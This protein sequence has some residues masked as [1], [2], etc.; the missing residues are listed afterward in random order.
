VAKLPE[1]TALAVLYVGAALAALLF[2]A[3]EVIAYMAR[4]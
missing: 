2:V 1:R 3:V 4:P